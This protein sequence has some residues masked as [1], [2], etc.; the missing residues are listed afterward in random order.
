[1]MVV[2]FSIIEPSLSLDGFEAFLRTYSHPTLED[3]LRPDR[4]G[5]RAQVKT[6]VLHCHGQLM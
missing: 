3:R 2:N 6:L 1:M 4:V 5:Y